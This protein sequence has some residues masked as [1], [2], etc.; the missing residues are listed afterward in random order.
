[1]RR[2]ANPAGPQDFVVT[3]LCLGGVVA[4]IAG[5]FAISEYRRRKRA[6]AMEQV[7]GDLGLEFIPKADGTFTF[8][9]SGFELTSKGR[10]QKAVNVLQGKS[11]NRALALFDYQYTTGH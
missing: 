2:N 5:L 3:I 8:N 1:M 11:D 4:L 10:A 7:A 6:A 9:L